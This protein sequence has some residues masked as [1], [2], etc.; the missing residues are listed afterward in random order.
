MAKLK[1]LFSGVLMLLVLS[2]AEAQNLQLAG[3]VLD[4]GL[5]L[6]GATI[7]IKGT[8]NGTITGIDGDFTLS[9]KVGDTLI[10][11][12]VGYLTQEVIPVDNT[13]LTINMLTDATEMEEVVVIG[14]GSVK[15][16]DLTGSVVSLKSEDILNTTVSS[17]DQ[18]LQ[19]KAAGVVVTQTS[20]Q[21]GASSSIR[22][23]GTSS[24]RG[25]NE[26]LYVVDGVP[27]IS[28]PNQGSTGAVQ[29]PAFNPLNSINSADIESIE[30]LKDASATAIYGAR[31]ANGVILVSTK[32]GAKGK[33]VINAAI[34]G[35]VQRVRKTLDMLN[36]SELAML[37]NEAADNAG[38][39]RKVI[40]A[41]PI[42]LGEGTNWQDEIF[43][44]APIVNAQFGVSGGK[45]G[46]SYLVSANIFSQ[47]GV[48]IGSDFTRGIFRVNL[49]QKL[50]DKVKIGTSIN[51]N[52]SVI[53]G[54]VTDSEGAIPSSIT[55][56]ALEF[57]PGL[58]VYDNNGQYVYENNTSQPAVGNPVADANENQQRTT[59]NKV[60]SSLYLSWEVLP[61]LVF[62]T[63]VGVDAF[64]NKEEAFTPN[65]LKRAE[66]SKGAA[67]V[68][69]SDGYTWLWENTLAYNKSFNDQSIN[70][71]VGYTMQAY[72][73][74]FMFGSTSDFDDN[75]L[76][77]NSLQAGKKKT[78]LINGAAGWQMMS[79]L[80]R[81]N[82]VLKDKYLA[83]ASLRVDG[84]SKFGDGNKFGYFPSFS[85]AWRIGNEDFLVNSLTISEL[86]LRA[87]YGTVGN[88]GIPSYSSLG[89]LEITE[90]YF[91]ESEIA[92]G[93]GP[94]SPE[95]ANLKW[96]TTHQFDIGVDL[97]L[98]NNRVSVTADIYYK[99]TVDLLLDRA[100][101]Y[102]SG[103]TNVF[104]NV[105]NL[106]NRGIELSVNSVNTTGELKWNTSLNFAVNR[107]K[108]TKLTG[109]ENERLLATPLLGI[110]G[111]S[112]ITVG[113]PIGS[114]Y[115]YETDGIIQLGESVGDIPYFSDYSPMHGDRKYIDQNGD[116]IINDLDKVRLGDANP[117]FSFGLGN[118]ISYKSFELNFFF[119]GVVGNKIANF[120]R[121]GLESFDGNRNNSR[122]ALKR[123]TPTNPTNEY[124]RANATPRA[125]AFSDIHVESGSYLRLRDV[126]ISYNFSS[127]FNDRLKLSSARV[128]VS[129]KNLL[130]ITDYSGYD[131]E[132]NRFPFNN[133]NMGADFGS[134]PQTMIFTGG[135]NLTF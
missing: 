66:A 93:A 130:T 19:G 31:G 13:P 67:T 41:S 5:P 53:N 90:A 75:R 58:G 51:L 101:P 124:P 133:L 87:G 63:Q 68:A 118:V 38:V 6:P 64:F 52:R 14:Y 23:R 126:T 36:A 113:S 127:K 119:Q 83:T 4:D 40:Y 28:D 26:P 8:T 54:V 99:N 108:I 34:S 3:T 79:F 18:G 32:R 129:V 44:L 110:N 60:F 46:T 111:W 107:N 39:P 85:L 117:K 100:V 24:I 128:Y 48:I 20:G 80:G 120:N 77:F 104:D 94:L 9:I 73:G 47:Q 135:L 72:N 96:E 103:F 70:A 76:G 86:K 112:Q 92:K 84:S 7:R 25:T 12:F 114:F 1:Y 65:F 81:V 16:S 131:P 78:L 134:Y 132:V 21:P 59:T 61:S 115:G 29:G 17:L 42:N 121:F 30:I 27:I 71:I 122:V 89:L 50:S 11:S 125:N 56:W 55:S 2:L 106:E 49:D 98:F 95:N 22:I 97:G 91:G 102:L 109:E 74:K 15:K 45:D 37:G 88:E 10:V 116:G 105:G 69:N 82:Y 33:T 57:N 123:W 35:G 62:K 43:R